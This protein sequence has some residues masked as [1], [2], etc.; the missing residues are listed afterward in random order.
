[1]HRDAS[2]R[3]PQEIIFIRH[4]AQTSNFRRRFALGINVLSEVVSGLFPKLS[5]ARTPVLPSERATA[6]RLLRLCRADVALHHEK[7]TLEAIPYQKIND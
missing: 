3:Y 7:I 6:A 5:T 4:D 1:V 2:A